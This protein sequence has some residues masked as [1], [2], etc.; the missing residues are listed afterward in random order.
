[1]QQSRE[2]K[3]A[4]LMAKAEQLIDEY[5]VWEESHPRPDL[6]EIEDIYYCPAC[7]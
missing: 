7:R 2:E 6:T 5:L 3:R 1:M 4:R